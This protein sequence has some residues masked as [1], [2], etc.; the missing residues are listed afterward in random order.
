MA[1]DRDVVIVGAGISGLH[2]ALTLEAK[3]AS[4]V[5]IEA[6]QRVRAHEAGGGPEQ[7]ALAGDIGF[8]LAWRVS[9]R[10]AISPRRSARARSRAAPSR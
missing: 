6:Q 2:A 4:V 8:A 10:M 1:F 7:R 3:G 9:V 5:V